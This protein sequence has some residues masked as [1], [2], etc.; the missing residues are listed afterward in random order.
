MGLKDYLGKFAIFVQNYCRNC[1]LPV[2]P[3]I[4]EETEIDE[5]IITVN[6]III[7]VNNS[8]LK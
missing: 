6:G 2:A 4:A 8:N 3:E 5:S 7:T 1:E